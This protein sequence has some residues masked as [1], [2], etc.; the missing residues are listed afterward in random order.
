VSVRSGV[1]ASARGRGA[2]AAL[3]LLLAACAPAAGAKGGSAPAPVVLVSFDGFRWD[4]AGRTETPNLDRLAATGVRAERLVPVF[5]SK[6]YPGHWSIA[7]GL[8]PGHHGILSNDLRDPRWPEVFR[9][10]ARAE[11]ENGRWWGGEPVWATARR[12]GLRSGVYFWPGSEGPIG[13]VSP[14]WAFRY[15]GAVAWEARVDAA[16][17]WLT[18]PE[19]ERASF[20]ALYFEEPNDAGHAHG[21][22]APETL[23]AVR[24][25]DAILGRLLDGLAARGVA[26]VVVVVSDHGMTATDPARTIVLDDLVDLRPGELLEFG[27]VGQIYPEAGRA[28]ALFAALAGAHPELAVYRR[29]EVPERL[30][31]FDHPRVAPLLLVPSPGWQVVPRSLPDGEPPRI[32]AGDHGWDPSHPDM[33]GLLYAAGPGIAVG[34]TLGAVEQVDVYA[35]LCRLLGVEPAPNDGVWARVAGALAASP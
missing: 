9:L 2:A 3:A 28:A 35:L 6:T 7:T 23:A 27:A 21:P 29:G 11:V 10:S 17:A 5:P 15:D 22:D 32:Q 4:Y 13:G 16:L 20:V 8:Y 24:R 30:H 19:G 26:A 34:R 33:H 14:D 18:L 31:L 1:C 25:A 12:H